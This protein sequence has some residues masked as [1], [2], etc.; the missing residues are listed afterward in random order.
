MQFVLFVTPR[1][2]KKVVNRV[3]CL[4]STVDTKRCCDTRLDNRGVTGLTKN[5]LEC[6]VKSRNSIVGRATDVTSRDVLFIFSC[7]RFPRLFLRNSR[8]CISF[9]YSRRRFN[10]RHD[11][12]L[13]R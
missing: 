8:T 12:I 10:D 6:G 9:L 11:C 4:V 13:Q 5:C 2:Y 3:F 1:F 7:P